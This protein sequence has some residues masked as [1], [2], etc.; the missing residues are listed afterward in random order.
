MEVARGW[1]FCED[2]SFSLEIIKDIKESETLRMYNEWREFLERPNTPGEWTKMAIV[3]T[4][5]A[6]MARDSGSGSMSFHLSQVMTGHGCFANF[7]R[8]IG[9]RMDATCDFCGEEDDVFYTIRECPVWDPQRIRP[10]RKLELSRDF[11]LGD[12]VEAC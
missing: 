10:Q 5:E 4:L 8:R 7:L 11:T 12:V 9:K 3:L 2:G 1:K 6:W